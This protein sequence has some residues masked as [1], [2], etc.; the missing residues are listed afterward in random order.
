M[1]AIA[2][3]AT[4]T[5]G[6]SR[7]PAVFKLHYANPTTVAWMPLWIYGTIFAMNWLIWLIIF[8]ASSPEGRVGMS[9]GTAWSGA[10]L[11]IF[12]WLL[13]LA[14]QAM[15]R[16]FHLALGF[17]STRRDYYLGTAAALVLACA[18]WAIVFGIMGALEEATNGWG[19]GG[20]M[21]AP[22]YFGDDGPIAR[23]WYVFLVMLFL[24]SI[25]LVA[26]AAWVRWR[27]F[28]VIGFFTIVAFLLIGGLAWVA[29]TDSWPELG[30]AMQTLGFSGVYALLL[31]P[32]AIAGLIG[33]LAL[34]RAT[35]RS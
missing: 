16:T 34:R 32:T 1:N 27:T 14:V 19:L 2:I 30:A 31:V 25:G 28:G 5:P 12:V 7:I 15:N 11:F 17:G 6:R 26:G 3:P 4:R 21:F 35:A 24:T 18:G 33:Y 9:T 20:H 8:N 29:L 23:T 10:S 13:V 22:I